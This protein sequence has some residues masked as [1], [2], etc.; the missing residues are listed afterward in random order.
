[1]SGVGA[2][3]LPAFISYL[4]LVIGIGI[5][6]TRFSSSG[7]SEFFVGGR[8]MHR[9]VVALSA[10][11]SGRSAWLVL[12]LTGTAYRIGAAAVWAVVGYITVEMLLLLFYASRLRRFSEA[13]DT[14]TVPDFFAERFGDRGGLRLAIVA[15]ILF[16]L[17]GYLSAQFIA[18]GKAFAV[19]FGLKPVTGILLTA[20]IVLLYTT[21]GGFLAVSLTDVLQAFFMILALVALPIVVISSQGGLA[22]ALQELAALKPGMLDPAVL[23]FGILLGFLAIGLGAP[24]NPHILARYISIADPSELRWAAVV[25]TVWNVVMAWGALFIGLVGRIVFPT[26]ES[27]TGDTEN[28]YPMLAREHFPPILFGLVIASIFA[29]IM[30]TA[31]S[32][33]LVAASGIAR[34]IYE[35]L[36][37]RAEIVPQRK[38]ILVSRI[39]VAI[40][41]VGALSFSLVPHQLIFWLVLF[42]WSGLGAALGPTSILALYWRRTS[43]AGVLAGILVGAATTLIW[44]LTP[45]LKGFVYELI[46]AFILGLL[47]TV[48]VSLCT[49]PPHGV[50]QMF[51]RMKG[52]GI[53]NHAGHELPGR[54]AP[55]S[56]SSSLPDHSRCVRH[57]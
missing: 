23:S 4:V 15:V 3:A 5:Y 53:G 50:H 6:A 37:R 35:K 48:I 46:P 20:G 8:K 45:M 2:G 10:V 21:L 9:F 41:V 29:A 1:M 18:G 16:F 25:G 33:L 7:V 22:P 38:L 27:L 43:R 28:L 54:H 39:V 47:V 24:G 55:G 11:V 51:Q 17:V 56:R 36:I 32:Q 30:S 13:Y 44:G 31:D 26:V 40:V 12:G 42:S 57:S 34:D 19:G 49:S 52:A 14:I